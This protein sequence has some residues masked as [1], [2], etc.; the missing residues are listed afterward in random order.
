MVQKGIRILIRSGYKKTEAEKFKEIYEA[1]GTLK[2]SQKRAFYDQFCYA[3]FENN[4]CKEKEL[5]NS[6]KIMNICL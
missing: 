5:E 6:K 2:K 1:Y 3:T 4:N